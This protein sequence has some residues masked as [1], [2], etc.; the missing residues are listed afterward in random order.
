MAKLVEFCVSL[1]HI[2]S[3][4]QILAGGAQWIDRSSRLGFVLHSRLRKL[5]APFAVILQE[6]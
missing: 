3:A 5:D 6:C 1:W 2:A 4:A